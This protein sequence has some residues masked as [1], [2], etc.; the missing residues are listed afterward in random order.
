ML[1]KWRLEDNLNKSVIFFYYESPR[2][3]TQLA[4]FGDKCFYHLYYLSDP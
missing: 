4:K 3:R 2:A 1:H